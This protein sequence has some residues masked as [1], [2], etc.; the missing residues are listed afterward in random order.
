M[1]KRIRI[2]WVVLGVVVVLFLWLVGEI[3]VS[4]PVYPAFQKQV[5]SYT[6]LQ[7]ALKDNQKIILPSPSK[8]ELTDETYCL[9]LD[10]RSI[11]SHPDGYSFCG[12]MLNNGVEVDFILDCD[13]FTSDLH[14][15]DTSYRDIYLKYDTWESSTDPIFK[16]ISI[17]F[18]LEEQHYSF[19]ATYHHG[20]LTK[21]EIAALEE[22]IRPQ[23]LELAQQVIDCYFDKG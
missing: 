6:E 23:L 13:K 21:E 2:K 1:K 10:G 14:N 20:T 17:Q 18:S 11:F 5:G 8:L 7:Q 19:E 15:P 22:A 16:S 12:T 3:I 9:R 4:I